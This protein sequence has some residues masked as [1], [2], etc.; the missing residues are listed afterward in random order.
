MS[1]LFCDLISGKRKK[2]RNK[3]PFIVIHETRYSISFLSTD[4]PKNE[5][6]HILITPKKHYQYLEEMPDFALEDLI[7]HVALACKIVRQNHEACNVLLND[8]SEAGQVIPHIHF[9]I[10]P[11]DPKDKIRIEVWYSGKSS[12]DEYKKL[13]L[14]LKKKFSSGKNHQQ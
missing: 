4:Q 13:S 2:H 11:R 6:A 7:K 5:K 3:F 12:L 10:I 14:E 1:C 8:G 9:H